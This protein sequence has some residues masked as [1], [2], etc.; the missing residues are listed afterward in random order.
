LVLGHFFKAAPCTYSKKRKG[1][2][3]SSWGN[4]TSELR[5]ITC[6]MGSHSV[7]CHLTQVNTPRLTPVHSRAGWCSIY[8]PR[9]D[10]RLSWPSWL[11]SASAGSQTSDLS[12][13]SPMPNHCTTKTTQ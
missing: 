7:T 8:L 5:D 3:I 4:P 9:R 2:Y 6:H 1:G 13:T 10:V 12:I 11:D